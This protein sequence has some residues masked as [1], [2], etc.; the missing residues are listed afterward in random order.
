MRFALLWPTFLILFTKV[1]QAELYPSAASYINLIISVTP[2][3]SQKQ[4]TYLKLFPSYEV[5]KSPFLINKIQ[6]AASLETGNG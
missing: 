4:V 2:F 5:Q 3:L 6:N 1:H